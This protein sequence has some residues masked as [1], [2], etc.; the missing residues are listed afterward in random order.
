M[1][2][3]DRVLVWLLVLALAAVI[4]GL[5]HFLFGAP[6]WMAIVITIIAIVVNGWIAG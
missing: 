4:S 2:R 5:A 6:W 1:G 3:R